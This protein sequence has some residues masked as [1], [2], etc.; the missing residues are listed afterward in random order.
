M[1][2]HCSCRRRLLGWAAISAASAIA[3]LGLLSGCS[4]QAAQQLRLGREEL[5]TERAAQPL[6]GS[7]RNHVALCKKPWQICD[8]AG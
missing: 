4:E 1:T 3:P 7:R 6:G 5:A 8:P 2:Y